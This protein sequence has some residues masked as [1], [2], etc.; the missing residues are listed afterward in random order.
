MQGPDINR[1]TFMTRVYHQS[2]ICFWD[3]EWKNNR[4]VSVFHLFVFS[5][6]LF[7]KNKKKVN[8]SVLATGLN[9]IYYFSLSVIQ[10]FTKTLSFYNNTTSASPAPASLLPEVWSLE[11]SD[12]PPRPCLWRPVTASLQ[13]S[14]SSEK[15]VYSLAR[16]HL[17]NKFSR[18]LWGHTKCHSPF[19]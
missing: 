8:N 13:L 12:Q 15:W 6:L 4:T 9:I 11:T 17:I 10:N 18:K 5:I 1:V 19:L 16:K 2:H 14:Q 3:E 7:P